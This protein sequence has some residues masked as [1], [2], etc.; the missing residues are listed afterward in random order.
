LTWHIEQGT[1]GLVIAGTTGESATLT[2]EEHC[3]LIDHAVKRV[4]GRLPV[5]AGTGANATREAVTLTK[6]AKELGADAALLVTPYYNKPTQEG[7]YQ[8]Y[9]HIAEQVDLPQI[10]YNVP[11]RTCCDLLPATVARLALI[12]NI[13]GIK[14][15]SGD[16][17]RVATLKSSC[18]D[19]FALYSG[20]DHSAVEFIL[21]GGQ[22]SISVTANVVPDLVAESHNLA[23]AKQEQQAR[24]LQ[25]KLQVLH[26]A[27][28]IESNPIPVKW[29]LSKMA[30]IATG[31]RLPLTPL[32]SEHHATLEQALTQLHC[33]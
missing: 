6:A 24:E 16:L 11:G 29:A 20:D 18:G 13:I 25:N 14:E 23:L 31:I 26:Q 7:L 2:V 28:F 19:N 22:G 5:I 4:K 30:K 3:A 9:K 10:L 33:I 15:V 32:A 12:D 1:Q 17:S 27:L 21:L 8:H